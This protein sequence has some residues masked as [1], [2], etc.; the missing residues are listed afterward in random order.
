MINEQELISCHRCARCF[1]SEVGLIY[2]TCPFCDYVCQLKIDLNILTE[3]QIEKL[4][5]KECGR[6]RKFGDFDTAK[7]SIERMKA[8]DKMHMN[9]YKCRF[10]SFYHIGH[11]ESVV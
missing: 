7:H 11:G 5:Q 8:R 4:R 3:A 2:A 6:K 1:Y 10:C 9:V